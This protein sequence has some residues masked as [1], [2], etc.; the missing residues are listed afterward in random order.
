M[1]SQLWVELLA[2]LFLL[3]KRR[4]KN[5]RGMVVPKQ[6]FL[7]HRRCCSAPCW[8]LCLCGFDGSFPLLRQQCAS[9]HVVAGVLIDPCRL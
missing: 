4:K 6:V 1:I 8:L 9:R 7:F 2:A 5:D 3:S